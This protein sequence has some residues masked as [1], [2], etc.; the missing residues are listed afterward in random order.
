MDDLL[1]CSGRHA[2]VTEAASGM[3]AAS[4][5]IMT[6]LGASVTVASGSRSA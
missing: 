5:Q 4:A 1:G 6:G 2:V 3:D